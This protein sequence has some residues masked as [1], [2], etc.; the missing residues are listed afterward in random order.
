MPDR[1]GVV[2]APERVFRS[3]PLKTLRKVDYGY[4]EWETVCGLLGLDPVRTVC[5][6]LPALQLTVETAPTFVGVEK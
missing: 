4:H 1:V 5:V 6:T 3:V 2:L